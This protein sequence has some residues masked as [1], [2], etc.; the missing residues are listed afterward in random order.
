[1]HNFCSI[2]KQQ[3]IKLLEMSIQREKLMTTKNYEKNKIDSLKGNLPDG[4]S[5]R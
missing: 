1:M 3:L 2:V 5:I 4:T